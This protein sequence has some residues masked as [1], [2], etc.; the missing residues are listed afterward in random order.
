MNPLLASTA[1]Y[2]TYLR[3]RMTSAKNSKKGGAELK[4]VDATTSEDPFCV[5]GSKA[6][7]RQQT[8]PVSAS[9]TSRDRDRSPQAK[10]GHENNVTAMEHSWRIHL[11][12]QRSSLQSSSALPLR[13]NSSSVIP[14]SISIKSVQRSS[15]QR[16][17]EK[18]DLQATGRTGAGSRWPPPAEPPEVDIQSPLPR[19]RPPASMI[20]PASSGQS[21]GG[22]GM[23]FYLIQ[24]LGSELSYLVSFV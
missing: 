9:R 2:D 11:T 20:L 4:N 23:C 3:N 12:H 6:N 10:T 21:R 22:I 7:S 5:T 14:M 16:D 24:V 1:E 19:H 18:W 15:Y 13:E 8:R 17:E